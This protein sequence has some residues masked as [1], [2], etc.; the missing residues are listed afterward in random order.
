MANP[1]GKPNV[2]ALLKNSGK[3]SPPG[4]PSQVPAPFG[5]YYNST[6]GLL[7][8]PNVSDEAI[9]LKNSG[10][11]KYDLMHQQAL[12]TIGKQPVFSQAAP[13]DTTTGS[14][15]A[16]MWGGIAGQQAAMQNLASRRGFNPGAYRAA[17][18]AGGELESRGWGLANQI[19]G[20]EEMRRQQMLLAAQQG[21]SQSEIE[22]QGLD[23]LKYQEMEQDE[24][25]RKKLFDVKAAGKEE[26][27]NAAFRGVGSAADSMTSFGAMS[28]ERAKQNAYM[29]GRQD[30]DALVRSLGDSGERRGTAL[31]E[32]RLD[33]M[34][35]TTNMAPSERSAQ[36]A[37][38]IDDRNQARERAELFYRSGVPRTEADQR[39][40][41]RDTSGNLEEI[42]LDRRLAGPTLQYG[43]A[44]VGGRMASLNA[45]MAARNAAPARV[46]MPQ[47]Y[48][49]VAALGDR[50][51]SELEALRR[52]QPSLLPAVVPR[53][54]FSMMPPPASEWVPS[55]PSPMVASRTRPMGDVIAEAE[56]RIQPSP[57]RPLPPSEWVP[58]RPPGDLIR[59]AEYRIQPSRFAAPPPPEWP[60][61]A[62]E[63]PQMSQWPRLPSPDQG[64]PYAFQPIGTVLSDE[65]VKRQAFEAGRSAQDQLI[66]TLGPSASDLRTEQ[67]VEGL[68]ELER[69]KA[70]GLE[71]SKAE[72]WRA[73]VRAREPIGYTFRQE[74]RL[75]GLPTTQEEIDEAL[76]RVLAPIPRLDEYP[77]TKPR[78]ETPLAD[79]HRDWLLERYGQA[80]TNKTPAW[81]FENQEDSPQR[82]FARETGENWMRSHLPIGSVL[83]DEREKRRAFEAGQASQDALINRLAAGRVQKPLT[84]LRRARIGNEF[85]PSVERERSLNEDQRQQIADYSGF[86]RQQAAAEADVKADELTRSIRPQTYEYKPEA[87]AAFGLHPGQR[88]GVM[89][90]D[91]EKTPLGKTMVVNTPMGKMIEP[92]AA[93]GATLAALGRLGQRLDLLESE[94]K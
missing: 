65:R 94:K 7:R 63:W 77:S 71:A 80:E 1:Y 2:Y 90:Q 12:N 9:A 40:I 85:V 84:G 31:V 38:M 76:G 23:F 66:R 32:E 43:E 19:R 24:A 52:V 87:T 51:M 45:E 33:A 55:A 92:R 5:F 60:P 68:D 6:G 72:A 4:Q 8:D 62:S 3:L 73:P 89:A 15:E 75:P 10:R 46:P 57:M 17:T 44:P 14:A 93:L 70:T 41:D 11:E 28:D 78:I 42:E 83:S 20:A 54:P 48:E 21:R 27:F 88:Y 58:T 50:T 47:Q 16:Q 64:I 86:F 69:R 61:P 18:Y 26:E 53:L 35:A 37:Q 79:A 34:K 30:Q 29:A 22:Q 36:L 67:L 39:K 56:Y 49:D 82:R 25:H 59:E 74:D 81:I 13:K 91:L